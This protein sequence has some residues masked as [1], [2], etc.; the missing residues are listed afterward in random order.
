[1][2]FPWLN[3]KVLLGCVYGVNKINRRRHTNNI[4]MAWMSHSSP[5]ICLLRYYMYDKRDENRNNKKKLIIYLFCFYYAL[6]P[7]IV[8]VL[9][10]DSGHSSMGNIERFIA[11]S[12]RTFICFYFFIWSYGNVISDCFL[13]A[14]FFYEF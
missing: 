10:L 12:L 7:C 13:P 2:T 11:D 5:L 1:M 9:R 14:I 8:W 6:I 3:L 4:F